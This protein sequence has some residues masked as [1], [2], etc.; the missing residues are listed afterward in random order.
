MWGR[1]KEKYNKVLLVVRG[2]VGYLIFLNLIFISNTKNKIGL[3][4]S[5]YACLFII[6][7]LI[8]LN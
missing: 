6:P 1:I 2:P 8:I 4:F 7:I 3:F 5:Y